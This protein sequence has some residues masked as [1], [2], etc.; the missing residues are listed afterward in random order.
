[1]CVWILRHCERSEAIH[2]LL[3]LWIASRSLSS[4]AHSRDPLARN[5]GSPSQLSRLFEIRIGQR[6]ERA[7]S[8]RAGAA[9][10]VVILVR[11][12]S[13]LS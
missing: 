6:M 11:G 13:T 8:V 12:V 1:M 4:G 5:D 10:A 2:L 3:R 9:V 7:V